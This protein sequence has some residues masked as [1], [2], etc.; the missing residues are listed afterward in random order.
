MTPPATGGRKQEIERLERQ[1]AR[2]MGTAIAEWDLI[3]SGDRILVGVSGGKDSYTLLHLLRR[4]QRRAPVPFD[5]VAVHLDQAHPGFDAGR[6]RAH[7]EEEGFP[8]RV[9]RKDTYS[10][11]VE[12]IADG[13][14]TCSLCSRYRRGILY[15]QAAELGCNKVALGHHRDD[16]LQT[17]L[18]N[19]FFSGRI[20]AMPAR[21]ET[22]DGRFTVIRPLI[23]A[24]Q[25]GIAQYAALKEFPI[26]PCRLC[27]ETER[28]AVD[29]LLR[30][31]S[32]RNPK[33]PAHLLAALHNVVPSHLLDRSLLARTSGLPTSAD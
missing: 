11:V 32:E 10:L 31:L 23:Y 4:F 33:V 9:I 20:A 26:E 19:A 21:L 17:F 29:Q 16:V 1:L 24:A 30:G 18:L 5:F 15:N 27:T 2:P 12:R 28:D 13:D 7:L 6:I 3:E 22:D 25:E 14:T 8:H